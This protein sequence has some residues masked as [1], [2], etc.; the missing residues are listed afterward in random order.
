MDEFSEKM[1]S[2]SLFSVVSGWFKSGIVEIS[3]S[4]KVGQIRLMLN[5][6]KNDKKRVAQ[7]MGLKVYSL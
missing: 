4:S 5:G 3:C 7:D 2:K 1:A 6:L